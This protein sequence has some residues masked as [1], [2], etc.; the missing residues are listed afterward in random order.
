[1]DN[2]DYKITIEQRI[3][4]LETIVEDIRDNHLHTMNK[5]MNWMIGLFVTG[6]IGIIGILVQLIL[7]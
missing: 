4:R 5:K 2:G 3:T 1:M 7:A 6:L